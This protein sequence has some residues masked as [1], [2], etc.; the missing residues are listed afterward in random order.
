[1]KQKTKI[2]LVEDDKNLGFVIRDSL[3]TNN[4]YVEHAMDGNTG[5]QKIFSSEFDLCLLDIMLPKKDGFTMAE[6]IRKAGK[7]IPIIFLTARGLKE[8]RIRGFQVGGDDYI[9][10]PFNLEELHLRIEAILRRSGKLKQ[11]ENKDHKI[12]NIGNYVF[13]SRDQTLASNSGSRTLT[14]KEAEVLEI[15]CLHPN[16]LITREKILVMVW[17]DDD[18]FKGRSLDVFITRLRKYLKDDPSIQI[19]N[20]HGTGFRL[21][22]SN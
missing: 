16:E 6:E 14:K 22:F 12:F 11:K 5:I 19:N 20:M 21:E 8:D 4:Y 2:L 3:E 13:N 7:N 1:M 15:L 18:Y 9:T 10:K 17:G